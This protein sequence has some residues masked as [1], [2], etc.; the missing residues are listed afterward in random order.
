MSRLSAIPHHGLV[1]VLLIFATATCL[2][3]VPASAAGKDAP[4]KAL[5]DWPEFRGP[6]G[7]GHVGK[8]D[9]DL[10][11]TWS[12]TENVKWKIAIPFQG[13][14]SPV[15]LGDQVWLTTATPDGKDFYAIC[16]DAKTGEIRFN[17]KLFHCDEPEPLGNEVN[18]YASPTPTIEP[19]RV[20]INFGSYGTACLDTKTFKVLWER[21]DLPCRHYRGPGSSII[22]YQDL[23]I[24]TFDG[25]DVQYITALDTKDGKTVW[26]TDR[27]TK[28]ADLDENGKPKREGDM[29]K[30]FSTPLVVNT[31]HATQM[32][33][34]GSSAAF[35]YDPRT[36]KELWTYRME[37]FT[38]AT[39][40]VYGNGLAYFTTG[41]GKQVLAAVRIDGKGDIT[42]TN[43][44]WKAEGGLV[45][46]QPSPLLDDGLLYLVSNNG[47]VTCLDA[48]TG[49]QVWSERIGGN[50][51]ASPIFANGRIY[52][53]N[54]QGKGT[55]LKA[56][57]AYEVLGTNTL[58]NGC[59]ATPAV[60]GN[61]IILRTKTHL[62]RI[63][64]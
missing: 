49:T 44:A 34:S 42:D 33:T 14:S 64:K 28:W 41:Q 10:P 58:E 30:A 1:A 25:I 57:K 4:K 53:F 38:P 24:V 5:A 36:G 39:R 40:P 13:W 50:Y 22:L 45:P 61:A 29:R 15:V 17:E 20:Y 21:K 37:G 56:G 7:D 62:Y 27:T 63:E 26:R 31:G 8:P 11:V 54:T 9:V 55:V 32:L 35:A 16:V 2:A 46:Q 59:M 23:L 3:Q 6:L 60:S 18:C 19:G 51:Q 12:E 48:A 52:F 47:L 43:T